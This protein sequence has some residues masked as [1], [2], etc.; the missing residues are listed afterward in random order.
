MSVQ[1][2]RIVIV[3]KDDVKPMVYFLNSKNKRLNEG[4]IKVPINATIG[5]LIT[6]LNKAKK[7]AWNEKI[8]KIQGVLEI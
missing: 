4:Y 5:E 3:I 1:G 6:M 7:Q 8:N 2:S